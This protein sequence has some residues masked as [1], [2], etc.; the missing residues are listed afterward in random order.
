MTD[1][2]T[3]LSGLIGSNLLDDDPSFEEIVVELVEALANR[4]QDMED[5]QPTSR[6]YKRWPIN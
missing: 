6:S 5:A 3:V 1:T 2:H 4:V